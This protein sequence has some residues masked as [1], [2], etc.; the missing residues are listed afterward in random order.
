[1]GNGIFDGYLKI[2]NGKIAEL[3][4]NDFVADCEYEFGED[5]VSPGFIDIHTHGGGGYDFLSESAEEI[6]KACDFHLQKGV[7][8]IAP[9]VSAASIDKMVSA[10]KAIKRAKQEKLTKLNIVGAHLEGPYLSKEQSGAQCPSFI[11]EPQKNEYEEIIRNFGD[12]IARWTYAPETDEDGSFCRFLKENGIVP[13]AGHTNAKYSNM[14]VAKNNGCNLI[15]HLYS[16]TSTVSR[17]GGFRSLGVIETAF[18]EDDLFVEIIA[19]GKHLPAELIKLILKI[20]GDDK[21]A[22]VTDSLALAGTDIK[23]GVMSG[24]PFIIEDGVCKLQDRSAFAG[25]I[26]TAD[27][28]VRVLTQEC[29]VSVVSAV[30]MITQVPAEIMGLNGKGSLEKGFDADIVVFDKDINVQAVFIGGNVL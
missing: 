19:D 17:K 8:S 13:S 1:M 20:K 27:R 30:K 6:A 3:C 23:E 29:G 18:L 14:L 11:K 26:A 2:V 25:S 21:V 10:V 5:F 9:T 15:T 24:T 7:T 28:L 12:Y 16:C 4:K 22:V